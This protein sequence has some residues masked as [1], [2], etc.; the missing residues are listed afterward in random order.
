MSGHVLPHTQLDDTGGVGR[1][2]DADS[3]DGQGPVKAACLSCRQKKA[4]CD[5]VQPSCGQVRR[6]IDGQHRT[7]AY[8]S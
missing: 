1:W 3:K 7:M 4:K 2:K 8:S 5:G 6:V